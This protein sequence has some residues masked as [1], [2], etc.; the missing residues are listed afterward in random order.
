MFRTHVARLGSLP[1]SAM[2]LACITLVGLVLRTNGIGLDLWIDEI[3]TLDKVRTATLTQMLTSYTSANDHILN[4]A[5]VSASIALFGEDEWSVRL[6]AM[7]FGVAS[8]PIVC[9]I[10][11]LS[12]LS[13]RASVCAA[14]I[15]AVSYHHIW[16][17]QNAR[18]Y[19][20]YLFFSLLGTG[21]LVRLLEAPRRR[22]QA[23]FI[24]A[25]IFNFLALLPSACVFGA[26]VL[27]AVTFLWFSAR[28]GEEVKKRAVGVLIALAATA[29]VGTLVF[30]PFLAEMFAVLDRDAPAQ[31]TAFRFFSIAFFREILR[32]LLPGSPS[33][34][35]VALAII[36]AGGAWGLFGLLRRAPVITGVLVGTHILLVVLTTVLGWP[37]YPR[38]FVLGL[39]LA[40]LVVL[41]VADA[42][43]TKVTRKP[44]RV[45]VPVL[46]ALL[47]MGCLAMIMRAHDVPKQPY[48]A[49]LAQLGRSSKPGSIVVAIGVVDRGI[50]Y[51]WDRVDERPTHLDYARTAKAFKSVC[52][53]HPTSRILLVSTFNGAL[54]IEEP[55][56]WGIMQDR[57]R[58]AMTL[59][60][61]VGGG[62]LTIWAPAK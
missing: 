8:I 55:E 33:I 43:D 53:S 49:A 34:W 54:A 46:T 22:W 28:R 38:L 29:V 36:A 32:G 47:I 4:S 21:A 25:S 44:L 60:A 62:G 26:Q 7:L 30:G 35:L 37:I 50:A 13:R 51:Y 18:G 1:R 52:A 20:A 48:R 14:L 42:I 45:V 5:L 9:W 2:V 31:V 41:A 40:I 6:P 61:T 56:L 58:P 27:S 11:S 16:F 59:P 24:A 10:A 19:T 15:L 3:A 12:G 23:I 39:P 57:W 17:S